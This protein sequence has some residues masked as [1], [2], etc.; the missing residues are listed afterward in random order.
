[1]IRRLVY[2]FGFIPYAA[3]LLVRWIVTGK[4]AINAM[5]RFER[6]AGV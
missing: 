1:M 4:S 6:W 3:Y 5:D 2:I